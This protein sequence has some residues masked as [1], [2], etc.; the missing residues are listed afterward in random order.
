MLHQLTQSNQSLLERI[1]KIEQQA[2]VSHPTTVAASLSTTSQP[3]ASIC[4]SRPQE[5]HT[6]P[7]FTQQLL[8]SSLAPQSLSARTVSNALAASYSCTCSVSRQ[9]STDSDTHSSTA[10]VQDDGVVP[11]LENLRRLPNISQA[12][13]SDLAAYEDQAKSSLLGKQ[14]RSGWYNTTDIAHNPPETRW[15]NERHHFSAGKKGVPYDELSMAQ[16]VAGQLSNVYNMKDP[17]TAKHALLQVIL[18]RMQH[19]YLGGQ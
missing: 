19:L 1:E 2:S 7:P 13:T 17:L 5:N 18:L 10:A 16:W 3:L 6:H 8:N 15:P 9:G 4:A 14:R 11:S 12:V